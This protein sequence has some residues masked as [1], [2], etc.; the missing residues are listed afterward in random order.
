[1]TKKLLLFINRNLQN[2]SIFKSGSSSCITILIPLFIIMLITLYGCEQ[3]HSKEKDYDSNTKLVELYPLLSDSPLAHAKLTFLPEETLL[4]SGDIEISVQEIDEQVNAASQR[5]KDQLKDNL[6][7]ILEQQFTE[8]VLLE[9][10]REKLLEDGMDTASMTDRQIFE[11]FFS[12]M[13][14]NIVITEK[15]INEFYTA[16]KE[17]MGGMPLKQAKPQIESYLIQQK[18]Q[19]VIEI[20]VSQTVSGK[21]VEIAYEWTKEQADRALDN[22]IDKA[23]ESGKPSFVNFG[24]DTCV[25]CQQMIPTREAVSEIYK[26][27]VNMVYIHVDKDQFLASRYGVQSIPTLVFFDKSGM[28]TKRHVGIM[29]QKQIEDQL[30]AL[31]D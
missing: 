28:E 23:R 15:E 29:T 9:E 8:I 6:F 7:F 13:T 26:G 21:E 17:V 1:M 31:L 19:Q 5:V 12:Q 27:K 14:G 2:K 3:I 18:Q 16:N 24:S 10:A 25:P 20:F 30:N 4:R 11:T 22:S